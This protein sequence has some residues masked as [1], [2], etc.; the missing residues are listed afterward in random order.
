MDIGR[1]FNY[2]FEDKDWL[3]KVLIGGLLVL[4]PIFGWCCIVAFFVE[5]IRN[6]KAGKDTPLPEWDNWGEKF[7]MGLQGFIT[8]LIYMV[9]AI[10]IGMIPCVGTLI[11]LPYQFLVIPVAW[12][13]FAK[14]GEIGKALQVSEAIEMIKVHWKDV[15]IVGLMQMVFGIVAMF[16]LIAL[17]IGVL[18]TG[19]W[20]NLAS[21]QLLGQLSRTVDPV[22]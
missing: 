11:A 5:Q 9:P 2:M 17:C 19:F 22:A 16:G 1:S 20:A 6:V 12:I 15:L 7:M 18:F 8:I 21:A 3:K 4:V 10:V 14:Y 13:M